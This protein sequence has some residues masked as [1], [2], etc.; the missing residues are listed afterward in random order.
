MNKA[1]IYYRWRELDDF[2][3]GKAIEGCRQQISLSKDAAR[4][5]KGMAI[6]PATTGS[7]SL[8]S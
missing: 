5:L 8:P 2:A 4:A 6:F 7:S 1:N 3:L